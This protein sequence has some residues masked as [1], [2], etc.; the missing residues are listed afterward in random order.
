MKPALEVKED[1]LIYLIP[2]T[3]AFVPS[4]LV[5]QQLLGFHLIGKHFPDLDTINPP[6][7][8]IYPIPDLQWK[9]QTWQMIGDREPKQVAIL[10]EST[11]STEQESQEEL[12]FDAYC[13]LIGAGPFNEPAFTIYRCLRSNGYSI[14]KTRKP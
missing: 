5:S 13:K 4:V 14:I 2:D 3:D 1:G 11:P 8:G 7:P 12:S 6:K 10:K 9:T